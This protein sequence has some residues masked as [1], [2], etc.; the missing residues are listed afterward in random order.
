MNRIMANASELYLQISIITPRKSNDGFVSHTTYDID[1]N[2][3][4]PGYKYGDTRV[5]R[6]YSDFVW[7]STELS[8]VCIGCI[9]PA[10]PVKQTVG[11]F[12]DDFVESRRKALERFLLLV[13]V[14]KDLNKS[15]AFVAFLQADR[16]SFETSKHLSESAAKMLSK[17]ALSWIDNKV[18]SISVGKVRGESEVQCIY[19]HIWIS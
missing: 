5:S 3:N 8:R 7:L 6:R 4:I 2:S 16:K 13:S 12:S 18:N 1:T 19:F 9:V 10:L 15:L 17:S 14:H 11:R